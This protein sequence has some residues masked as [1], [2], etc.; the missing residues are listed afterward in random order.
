MHNSIDSM[1]EEGTKPENA[2]KNVMY[3]SDRGCS[4]TVRTNLTINK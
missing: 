4:Y 2:E 1:I 3:L